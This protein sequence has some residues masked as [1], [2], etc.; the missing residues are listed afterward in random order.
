MRKYIAFFLIGSMTFLLLFSCDGGGGTGE[1]KF[2]V[3]DV[4][5]IIQEIGGEYNV[6]CPENVFLRLAFITEESEI[7]G[8]A[9]LFG[10][11]K[12]GKRVEI[13]GVLEGDSFSLDDFEVSGPGLRLSVSQFEGVLLGNFENESA[14]EIEGIAAGDLIFF[15]GDYVSCYGP[16][17]GE[18]SGE[19]KFPEG[20]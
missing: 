12:L 10:F 20:S 18:F 17:T 1:G 14:S 3:Y 19:A 11:G 7:S 4:N 9:R 2:T 8:Y 13:S 5:L 15:R 16:F 6:E